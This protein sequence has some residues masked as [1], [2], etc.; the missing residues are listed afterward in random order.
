KNIAYLPR[1]PDLFPVSLPGWIIPQGF[2]HLEKALARGKGVILLTAHYGF[3]EAMP[4]HVQQCTQ[5]LSMVA[6]PL[7]NHRVDRLINAA[8]ECNGGVVSPQHQM[9]KR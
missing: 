8:R 7:D 1:I 4:A 2:E 3:W 6:R 5:K 9:L